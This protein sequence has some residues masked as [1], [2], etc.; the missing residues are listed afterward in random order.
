LSQLGSEIGIGVG[1]VF[2]RF[3]ALDTHSK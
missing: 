2:H 1:S 3:R